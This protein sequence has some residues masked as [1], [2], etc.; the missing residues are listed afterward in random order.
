[1]AAS[2]LGGCAGYE[3]IG[4]PKISSGLSHQSTKYPYDF[5]VGYEGRQRDAR[6]DTLPMTSVFLCGAATSG[7]RVLTAIVAAC[8]VA[9]CG[10]SGGIEEQE[11]LEPPS[12]Q[13]LAAGDSLDS[14][15]MYVRALRTLRDSSPSGYDSMAT[16]FI[17]AIQM[18]LG[19]LGFGG[20]PFTGVADAST[21]AAIRSFEAARHL[22]QTGN[23]FNMA[24]FLRLEKD[25]EAVTRLERAFPARMPVFGFQNWDRGQVF[26]QGQ[27]LIQGNTSNAAAQIYCNRQSRACEVLVAKTDGPIM[28]GIQLDEDTYTI[29]LWDDVEIVSRPKDFLCARERLHI[30]KSP[31]SVRFVRTRLSE[32]D[33]C[34][35]GD[36]GGAHILTWDESERYRLGL[37]RSAFKLYAFEGRARELM[38]R[39]SQ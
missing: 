1:M 9:A 37:E 12:D 21:R 29:A 17:A 8:F 3:L 23:P 26:I 27:M 25:G 7:L 32:G 39:D 31:E 6:T 5:P 38:V 11:S 20:G 15:V 24:T 18:Q 35:S 14:G 30:A 16:V 19:K 10:A 2:R 4:V 33:L 13:E 22:P 36:A 28:G 34:G